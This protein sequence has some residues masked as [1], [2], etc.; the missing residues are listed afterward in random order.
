MSL[1]TVYVLSLLPI[2]PI[3]LYCFVVYTRPVSRF[4]APLPNSL[5]K[6]SYT[7]LYNTCAAAD[8]AAVVEVK[9]YALVTT[10]CEFVTGDPVYI[11]I[12][13][14]YIHIIYVYV[15]CEYIICIGAHNLCTR[16]IV[17]RFV[18]SVALV[19]LCCFHSIIYPHIIR[20]FIILVRTLPIYYYYN[21]DM[22]LVTNNSGS[23]ARVCILIVVLLCF[24]CTYL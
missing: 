11:H 2:K 9:H 22:W 8:A 7:Y 17:M 16:K 13:Y 14:T 21:I 23:P 5:K 15:F 24:V 4:N 12:N 10:L 20:E 1:H 3:F 19:A 6:I 18:C